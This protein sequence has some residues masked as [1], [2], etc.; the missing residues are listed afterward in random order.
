MRG[1]DMLP[2]IKHPGKHSKAT[3]LFEHTLC[4][5]IPLQGHVPARESNLGPLLLKASALPT[6]LPGRGFVMH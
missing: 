3:I 6:E 5:P 4:L 2:G 1:E